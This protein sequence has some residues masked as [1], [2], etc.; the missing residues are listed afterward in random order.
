MAELTGKLAE[1]SKKINSF[2]E[3]EQWEACISAGMECANLAENTPSVPN[4]LKAVIYSNLG[5]AHLKKGEYDTALHNYGISM[6]LNPNSS[7]IY[8]RRG[9]AYFHKK[10]YGHAV[11]EHSKGLKID[12]KDSSA[13]VNLG[14]AYFGSEKFD[15]AVSSYEEALKLD[16]TNLDA[17]HH[18]ELTISLKEARKEQEQIRQ[19][20][21]EKLE[22][23]T[24]QLKED[25]NKIIDK[26]E[27]N[28]L[29]NEEYDDQHD[30]FEKKAKDANAN[31]EKGFSRLKWGAAFAFVVTAGVV[32]YMLWQK[33]S[34]LAIL[35][36]ITAAGVCSFP[37]I[38]QIRTQ[39]QEN[40]R[41]LALSKDAYTKGIMANLINANPDPAVRKELLH[42]FFDY[43]A[44]HGSAQLII[45]L[46]NKT[47]SDGAAAN[48]PFKQLKDGMFDK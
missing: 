44:E 23:Q 13:F 22:Q 16:P 26:Y 45:D 25:L 35:P 2:A 46:E 1:L 34:M 31:V 19:Q 8:N 21:Q 42:K 29:R 47:K 30:A 38:W 32:I 33:P 17:I 27:V 7:S 11:L 41:W 37:F 14:N 5:F 24:E 12:S 9:V 36:V 10:E 6:A 4:I 18:R 28:L 20:Y 15:S 40:A 3:K 48:I 39:K 43:H